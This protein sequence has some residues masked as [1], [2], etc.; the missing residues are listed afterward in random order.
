MGL[1]TLD[2]HL[3]LLREG[4]LA[5]AHHAGQ[6][7]LTGTL[8][9]ERNRLR[10]EL[11]THRALLADCRTQR[12][13]LANEVG[14]WR[15]RHSEKVEALQVETEAHAATKEALRN[16]AIVVV[17]RDTAVAEL[18]EGRDTMERRGNDLAVELA[19]AREE[20]S[21]LTGERNRLKFERDTFA[22][23]RD[24]ASADR[25]RALEQVKAQIDKADLLYESLR[26]YGDEQGFGEEWDEFL[27]SLDITPRRRTF[28]VQTEVESIA[29][30]VPLRVEAYS[31]GEAC[32]TIMGRGTMPVEVKFPNGTTWTANLK[33]LQATEAREV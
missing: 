13:A 33:V 11:Q 16:S 31:E 17:E 12:N 4:R 9:A 1:R 22:A 10:T 5:A 30:P 15:E 29:D 18:R 25:N 27:M 8:V 20:L 23:Q 26:D 32:R 3:A 14:E 21:D 28:E 2:L 19:Q 6:A 24:E 7:T